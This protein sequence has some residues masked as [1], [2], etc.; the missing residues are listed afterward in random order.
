MSGRR[1]VDRAPSPDTLVVDLDE[2]EE[3]D[4]DESVVPP[5]APPA[6]VDF[7][8]GSEARPRRV[9]ASD[10]DTLSKVELE[11]LLLAYLLD[12]DEE[13]G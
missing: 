11:A 13:P 6:A 10:L 4:F 2:L 8:Q 3:F 12:R 9:A 5:A 1:P 7:A